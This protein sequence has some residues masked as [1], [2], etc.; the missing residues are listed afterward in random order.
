MP[1]RHEAA[2]AE[3]QPAERGAE[4]PGRS[5]RR[6]R[7]VLREWPHGVARPCPVLV[8]CHLMSRHAK[9]RV[10]ALVHVK[11]QQAEL[12]VEVLLMSTGRMLQEI[13]A[14]HRR[15]P[16]VHLRIGLLF[17]QDCVVVV[18]ARAQRTSN[19]TAVALTHAGATCHSLQ[20]SRQQ[21]PCRSISAYLA[22]SGRK[23]LY[24][25]SSSSGQR[26]FCSSMF[27]TRATKGSSI[28]PNTR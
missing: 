12:T 11:L 7:R 19:C 26:R 3:R 5:V 6:E 17:S 22:D 8:A 16:P 14:D 4:L 10:E 21:Q 24:R 23:V 1:I 13:R 2:A 15:V 25:S 18:H 9:Q 27:M 20:H 28:W